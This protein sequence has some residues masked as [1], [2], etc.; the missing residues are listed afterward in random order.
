MDNDFGTEFSNSGTNVTAKGGYRP[1]LYT[2]AAGSYA[3]NAVHAFSAALLHSYAS[4]QLPPGLT[5]VTLGSAFVSSKENCTFEQRGKEVTFTC[6]VTLGTTLNPGLGTEELRIHPM[7]RNPVEPK[8]YLRGLP[9]PAQPIDIPIVSLSVVNK[10]G[11]Q[12]V[13]DAGSPA[14]TYILGARVLTNGVIALIIRDLNIAAPNQWRGMTHND[15]GA[16]F[17]ADQ[18]IMFN[19]KGTYLADTSN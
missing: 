12:I 5:T 4:I 17:V 2:V 13:P 7:R 16:N 10:T 6:S 8:S 14:G 1:E 3:S 11:V 19:I 18:V 15:I 9:L